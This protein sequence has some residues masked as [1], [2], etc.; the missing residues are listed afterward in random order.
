[1]S[2]KKDISIL[3]GT[4]APSMD[5]IAALISEVRN[6]GGAE[7][8]VYGLE[9]PE[10]KILIPKIAELIMQKVHNTYKIT[11]DYNMSLAEMIKAGNY[12]WRNNDIN[13]IN[14]PTPPK[15]LRLGK[16]NVNIKLVCYGRDMTRNK[17]LVDLDSHGKRPGILPELLALGARFPFLQLEYP[18]VQIGSV[19]PDRG[20][21]RGTYLRRGNKE[22]GLS[23]IWLKYGFRGY[24]QIIAVQK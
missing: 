22:R 19:W 4:P 5:I 13:D 10:R 16:V 8:D 6:C 18:I 23:V 14:F 1:M 24:Y 21:L 7:E 11:V 3:A 9:T 12:D 15:Y 17:V 20:G 2:N